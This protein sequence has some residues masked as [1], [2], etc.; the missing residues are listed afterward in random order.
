MV[1]A[2]TNCYHRKLIVR[3]RITARF[4]LVIYTLAALGGI[5]DV[6]CCHDH[7]AHLAGA[8]A[9]HEYV[10]SRNRLV[11]H[12]F[13]HAALLAEQSSLA[14]PCCCCVYP[15]HEEA[16]LSTHVLT[17]HRNWSDFSIWLSPAVL[18]A[19]NDLGSTNAGMRVPPEH[20]QSLPAF[21]STHTIVL[22][23]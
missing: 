11:V 7:A 19:V 8:D 15:G 20:L 13:I 2:R 16:E 22:L 17:N 10:H 9:V 23:I 14:S 4:C 1:R 18:S 6:G 21:L 12:S 3:S 5:F